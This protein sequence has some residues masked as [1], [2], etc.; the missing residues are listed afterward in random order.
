[1]EA[2]LFNRIAYTIIIS[3]VLCFLK[4]CVPLAIIVLVGGIAWA[5]RKAKDEE[6]GRF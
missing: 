3:F 5:I 1:M 2:R 6:A 4:G